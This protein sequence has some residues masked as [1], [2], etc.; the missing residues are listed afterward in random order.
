MPTQRKSTTPTADEKHK[1]YAALYAKDKHVT[2]SKEDMY[3]ARCEV[4]G[5]RFAFLMSEY[6]MWYGSNDNAMICSSGHVC[7]FHI[8]QPKEK[9]GR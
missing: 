5:S 9:G 2:C 3:A 1:R 7:W 8:E 6:A 4:C